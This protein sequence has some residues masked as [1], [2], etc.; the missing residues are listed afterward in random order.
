MGTL[1]ISKICK[2]YPDRIK[3]SVMPSPKLYETT[4]EP[5]NATLSVHQLLTS[6]LFL[7]QH[8]LY[9]I[10]EYYDI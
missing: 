1:L 10:Q 5:Y 4:V 9:S 6:D 7:C 8:S 3:N 2:D